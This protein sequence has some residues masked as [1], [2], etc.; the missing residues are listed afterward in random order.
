[1]GSWVLI[2]ILMCAPHPSRKSPC[3]SQPSVSPPA[4]N[5][6]KLFSFIINFDSRKKSPLISKKAGLL[7]IIIFIRLVIVVV[8]NWTKQKLM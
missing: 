8:I 1:M 3:L 7:K 4:F 5:S 2:E 6:N